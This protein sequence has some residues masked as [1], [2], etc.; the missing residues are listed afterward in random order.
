MMRKTLLTTALLLGGL[1]TVPAQAGVQVLTSIKPLQLI[2][3]AVQDGTGSTPQVLLP[4]GASPH[5]YSLRPSDL[6]NL[7]QADLLYWIGPDL[8]TFLEKPL[9]TRKAPSL[10]VQ[11]IPG[12]QLRHFGDEE[13]AHDDAH[14][15]HAKHEEHEEHE[16]HGR[17]AHEHDHA[18][19]PGSLDAHLWLQPANARRIA[20]RMAADLSKAD[21]A[22][23]A[24]YASNLQT[25]AQ[26]L[27]Q[28]DRYLRD[29]LRGLR[30][31]PF[32]VFH[33]AFDYFEAAYDLRHRAVF[34]ISGEVQPGARHVAAMRAE[35]Q[36]AGHSCLFHEP[37][38]APKL[39]HSLT[40]GLPVT[41]AEL[42]PLGQDL[43]VEARSYE[44]L[45]SRLGN[46]MANCLRQL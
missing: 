30:Q 21:P 29:H 15:G 6:R 27:D 8:E 36:A 18:H 16:D 38:A 2:A 39:A 9:T 33:E 20:E 28:L 11:E 37:P 26:H 35:L 22:N 24:R 17:H 5:E 10:A 42:D 43:P 3:A 25:F 1:L 32:F 46:Q 40:A 34:A 44:T 12:L 45:L 41:L 7:Q 4:P 19:R 14:E 23:A 31:K 13:P